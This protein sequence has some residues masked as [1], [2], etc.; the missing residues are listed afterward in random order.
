M[1]E[2]IASDMTAG[3]NLVFKPIE[4]MMNQ[5]S[6]HL[7]KENASWLQKRGAGLT[8]LGPALDTRASLFVRRGKR[9]VSERPGEN[10]V[11]QLIATPRE[12][13]SFG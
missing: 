6:N 10:P 12:M 5:G 2:D 3:P 13:A 4:W 11:K 9:E 7:L 8:I 1:C